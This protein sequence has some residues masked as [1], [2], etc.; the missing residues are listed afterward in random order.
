MSTPRR[1]HVSSRP[2]RLLPNLILVICRDFFGMYS[3]LHR[4]VHHTTTVVFRDLGLDA[5]R[6]RRLLDQRTIHHVPRGYSQT[7]S[8]SRILSRPARLLPNLIP[9][10]A[11]L[12][13]NRIWLLPNLILRR[14]D[15]HGQRRLLDQR[16]IHHIPRGYSRI[17]LRPVRSLPHL[18]LVLARECLGVSSTFLVCLH[19]S[20]AILAS[21]ITNNGDSS[22]KDRFITSSVVGQLQGPHKE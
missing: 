8:Y 19:H 3:T 16:T 21:I 4:C 11:W 9:R 13:S 7:L 20:F 14:L 1:N 10:P 22:M 6:Q 17:L 2:A 5:H 15:A 18:I 12:L